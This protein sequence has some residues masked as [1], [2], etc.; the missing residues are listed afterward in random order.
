[1][2]VDYKTDMSKRMSGDYPTAGR[3]KLVATFRVEA[4]ESD[5]VRA[6]AF[7]ATQPQ[8]VSKWKL[9]K[10]LESLNVIRPKRP[11]KEDGTTSP[12]AFQAQTNVILDRLR[13]RGFVVTTG[14]RAEFRITLTEKGQDGYK[15]YRHAVEPR[16]SLSILEG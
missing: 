9:R 10:H 11:E 2:P 3:P 12:Q 4:L 7:L 15:M 5:A 6:L 16:L 1:M 8:P 14:K 13:E